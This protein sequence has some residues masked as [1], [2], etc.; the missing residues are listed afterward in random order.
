MVAAHAE[1]PGRVVIDIEPDRGLWV[2]ALNAAGYQMIF[3]VNPPG[4]GLLPGTPPPG[5]GGLVRCC[6][7]QA[8][9]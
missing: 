9:R 3:A 1:E 5:L 6:R 4:S 2:E 8:S 7:R